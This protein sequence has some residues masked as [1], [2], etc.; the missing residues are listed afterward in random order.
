MSDAHFM[1]ENTLLLW[2]DIE[3]IPANS[4][5]DL[6]RSFFQA[7]PDLEMSDPTWQ[8]RTRHDNGGHDFTMQDYDRIVNLEFS[9]AYDI[10]A[11]K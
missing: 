1:L 7:R 9:T 4:L 10:E 3:Q 5:K 11:Q 2:N 6:A 8:W